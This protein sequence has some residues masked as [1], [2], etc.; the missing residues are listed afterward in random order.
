MYLENLPDPCTAG[1]F[2]RFCCTYLLIFIML[3]ARRSY[4][5]RV[6]RRLTMKRIASALYVDVTQNVFYV[7]HALVI[8]IHTFPVNYFL[9]Q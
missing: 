2:C 5:A 3:S 9:N 7:S 8:S 1:L 6:D 4:H